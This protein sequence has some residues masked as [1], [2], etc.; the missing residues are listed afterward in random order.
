VGCVVTLLIILFA[1]AVYV[2]VELFDHNVAHIVVGGHKSAPAPTPRL[3][4]K[5]FK[6]VKLFGSKLEVFESLW[7][8]TQ[9]LSVFH[10]PHR[11]SEGFRPH[12]E[13]YALIDESKYL[14]ITSMDDAH[15]RDDKLDHKF[16][17]RKHVV[18]GRGFA[19]F[20][21]VFTEDR[22]VRSPMRTDTQIGFFIHAFPS[23]D[24]FGRKLNVGINTAYDFEKERQWVVFLGA[25]WPG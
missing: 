6:A 13:F 18:L 2:E 12:I 20:T 15:A 21:A 24:L 3:V 25:R 19:R 4:G 1:N 16:V 10:A 11:A 22:K 8:D 5:Q 17:I 7:F 14:H 9:Y 23:I